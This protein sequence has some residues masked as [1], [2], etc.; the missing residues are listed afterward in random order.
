MPVLRSEDD[1]GNVVARRA[2]M[3]AG[4]TSINIGDWYSDPPF[5]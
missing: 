5:S 1:L 2:A 3:K 4:F